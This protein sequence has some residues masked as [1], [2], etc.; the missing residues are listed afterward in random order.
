MAW[1][2]FGSSWLTH[3]FS[4]YFDRYVGTLFEIDSE[5]STVS[6]ERVQSHGTEG[7]CANP[8]DEVQGSENV[9]EFIVFRGSDVKD[10]RI[11][12]VEE[13]A[14]AAAPQVPDDPAI[15]GVSVIGQ[16]QILQ[17]SLFLATFFAIFT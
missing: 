4:L 5:K 6:L 14:K 15:L 16:C 13:A 7:R 1:Q 11:E 2:N 8:T 17:T 12:T 10:L 9:Y 3:L